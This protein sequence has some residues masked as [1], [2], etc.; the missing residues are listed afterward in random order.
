MVTTSRPLVLLMLVCSMASIA[1][2]QKKSPDASV[3]VGAPSPDSLGRLVLSRFATGTRESF[4]S[5]Y[6]DPLGRGLVYT[7]SQRHL[8]RRGELERVVWTDARRAILLLTGTIRS[9][10]QGDS[11]AAGVDE[12]SDETNR[13]LRF[14]GL[15][16]AAISRGQWAL[17]RR[18][19]FDTAN[20]IRAQ[21][22]HVALTPGRGIVVTDTLT[23][24]VGSPYGFIARLNNAVRLTHV[25][26]DG[27]T[28]IP[29]FG[30]G[31]FRIAMP[32]HEHAQL[33]MRY[34][35]ADDR[36][37]TAYG[38]YYNSDVWHPYFTHESGRDLAQINVTVQLPVAYRLSTTL[39]QAESVRGDV[40]TVIGHSMHPQFSLTLVYN[41]NWKVVSSTLPDGTRFQSFLSPNFRFSHDTLEKVIGRVYHVIGSRFGEPEA[42]S[43]YVAVVED[44]LI[45]DDGI[46]ARM[47]NA[48]ISGSN[49]TR[50]AE[51]IVGPSYVLAHETS[52]GWTMNSS[53][54]A[55]GMLQEGW[56]TYAEGLMLRDVYGA[57]TEHQFW[58][59]QRTGY[60]NGLD[61]GG[62]PGDSGVRQSILANPDSRGNQYYTG[63]W[64]FRSLNF[65]LGD[66]TFDRG[67]RA[68]IGHA[69]K[70]PNDY[71]EFIAAMSRAAGRDM[72]SFIMP[73][74]SAG[75][76][77]DVEARLDGLHVIVTQS[78]P[79]MLF[80]LPLDVV[81]TIA[82]GKIVLRH[83]HLTRR[84]DTLDVSDVETIVDVRV[85][86]ER[87]FLMKRHYGEIVRFEL[88]ASAVPLA[89]SVEL[90]GN[91]LTIPRAALRSGDSW[92]L[93]LPL[94]EG[95]YIW[96]W[97]VDGSAPPEDSIFTDITGGPPRSGARSGLLL[98]RAIRRV[99]ASLP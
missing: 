33:V 45:S 93:E 75:Y 74:L 55:V 73:W 10:I 61:R 82:S 18:I 86:P 44:E 13:V 66:S 77:P 51:P 65:V 34:A 43:R 68:F 21:N 57:D 59:R 7:T 48:V 72:N 50:L 95:R 12:G 36:G 9:N 58:E 32:P 23:I 85:D 16:E 30:G 24:D 63:A 3:T 14:S 37:K 78:Q 11:S 88:P 22:I 98:V 1:H 17:V 94:S 46:S 76:I 67:M 56:A 96:Q 40:R 71:R 41:R 81:L 70:G 89:K 91:F 28:V 52:H 49:A 20:L 54:Y 6:P 80:D 42:P 35:L 5:V 26:L 62:M 79:G 27:K 38:A 83:V 69:G 15:Y 19:P 87:H 4:D 84:A 47:D 2:A 29:L 64:I 92:S 90:S 31:M 60:M 8:V 53:G 25:Q 99:P 97:R 39:P